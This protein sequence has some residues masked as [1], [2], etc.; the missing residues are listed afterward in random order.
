MAAVLGV[1]PLQTSQTTLYMYLTHVTLYKYVI[2][3]SLN[4]LTCYVADYFLSCLYSV[5]C[6]CLAGP[7]FSKNLKSSSVLKDGE[8]NGYHGD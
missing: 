3:I 1:G 8:D 5:K 2:N 4:I 6:W 7:S